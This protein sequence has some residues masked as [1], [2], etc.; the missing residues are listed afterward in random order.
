MQI[1]VSVT[2]HRHF[3]PILNERLNTYSTTITPVLN[4]NVT[5]TE[6]DVEVIHL[7]SVAPT[8]ELNEAVTAPVIHDAFEA[9]P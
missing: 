9:V 1:C 4:V 2:I 3:I 5:A 6:V 8:T 7:I